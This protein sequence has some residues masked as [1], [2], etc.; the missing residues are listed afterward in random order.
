MK[1]TNHILTGNAIDFKQ[2]PN[3][4]GKFKSGL[5]DTIV[6]H[7]TAGSSRASSV[8]TLVNPASKASAH[9]VVG[10][11]GKITQLIPFNTIAW[12][13]GK[14][15]YDGRVGFN[16]YSIGIEIDNAGLLTKSGDK[17]LA[18]F[19]KDYPESEVIKAIHRNESTARYWHRYTEWQIETCRQICELL[20]EKYNIKSILGHE[21]ISPKRKIDPG[22][23]F[24]LDKFREKIFE[25]DRSENTEEPDIK[26]Q[27]GEVTASSLNIRSGPDVENEK[28]APA[29]SKGTKLTI[30]DAKDGW[31]KVR[32][33][34][35]GWVFAKHVKG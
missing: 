18:W 6:I 31:Y 9:L 7:Y 32:T 20:I 26:L 16:Q 11:D 35:E 34:V 33:E 2:S 27:I 28:I 8:N 22:P 1:I 12:H 14:S 5:P 29:L 21:E 13:A 4:S 17:Y 3:H 23:A 24:P 30:L 10:R 19:G 15:A 25:S